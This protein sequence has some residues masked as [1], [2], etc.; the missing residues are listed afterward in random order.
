MFGD[1]TSWLLSLVRMVFRDLWDFVQDSLIE[2]LD[3]F[4]K[5]LVLVVGSIPVPSFVQGGLGSLFGGLD[6]HILYFV[7]MFGVP[8]A[9]GLFG[10]A[11][12]FRLARKVVTLF[13]W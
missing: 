2:L 3:L 4:L 13:Q 6:P 5:A 11:F 12:A 8:Q 1:I 9:L 7:T 10:A